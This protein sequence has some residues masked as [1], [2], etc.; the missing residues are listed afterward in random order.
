M[1]PGN[2]STRCNQNNGKKRS[3][4]ENPVLQERDVN[5]SDSSDD[6]EKDEEKN[7]GKGTSNIEK[8]LAELRQKLSEAEKELAFTKGRAGESGGSASI[9]GIRIEKENI[10]VEKLT[11]ATRRCLKGFIIEYMWKC[12]KLLVNGTFTRNP[13]FDGRMFAKMQV[14]S[15][16]QN[17]IRLNCYKYIT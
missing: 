9:S 12:D 3:V 13:K 11:D 16:E 15:V 6:D 14:D 7:V 4:R 17:K 10:Q 2:C 5:S 1:M 8:E